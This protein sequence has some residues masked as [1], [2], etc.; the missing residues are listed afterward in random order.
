MTGNI[1]KQ[2]FMYMIT[3]MKSK[4]KQRKYE[5]NFKL[6]RASWPSQIAVL[7][8]RGVSRETLKMLLEKCSVRVYIVSYPKLENQVVQWIQEEARLQCCHK[9]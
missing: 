5:E 6:K 2:R 3:T 7:L 9:K 8:H 1:E 4:T